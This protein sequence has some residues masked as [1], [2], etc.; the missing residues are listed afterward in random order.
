MSVYTSVISIIYIIR[1]FPSTSEE[2]STTALLRFKRY[3]FFLGRRL[4]DLFVMRFIKST[5]TCQNHVHSPHIYS[6]FQRASPQG[7]AKKSEGIYSSP[8]K[9]ICDASLCILRTAFLQKLYCACVSHGMAQFVLT[10]ADLSILMEP[11]LLLEKGSA[12]VSYNAFGRYWYLNFA[13]MLAA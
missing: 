9:V 5:S 13:C 6:H 2:K 8:L 10:M 12:R 4:R 11:T 3:F 1:I 7:L